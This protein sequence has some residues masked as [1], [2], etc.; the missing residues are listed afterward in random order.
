[1]QKGTWLC[2]NVSYLC[3]SERGRTDAHYIAK[4]SFNSQSVQ[5]SLL[6]SSVILVQLFDS[7][8]FSVP[9]PAVYF[10]LTMFWIF[11]TGGPNETFKKWLQSYTEK[12]IMTKRSRTVK[13]LALTLKHSFSYS[14]QSIVSG[15]PGFPRVRL[16][17]RYVDIK[18]R[19]ISITSHSPLCEIFSFK[20]DGNDIRIFIP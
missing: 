14:P 1:M 20:R 8:F 12:L 17:T 5:C 15:Y 2:R 3:S 19:I 4:L 18:L 7:S 13:I 11:F 9:R 6:F 10:T 16:M